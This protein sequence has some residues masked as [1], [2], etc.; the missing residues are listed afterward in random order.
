MA[1][2]D[3]TKLRELLFVVVR[4]LQRFKKLRQEDDYRFSLD[5]DEASSS[6]PAARFGEIILEGGG[7]GVHLLV[8][9]DTYNNLARWVNRK[10]LSEFE[11]RVLFQMSANDSANLIDSQAASNLGLH[12]AL[13]YNEHEGTLET[14]RPYALPESDWIEEI[15]GQIAR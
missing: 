9:V 1:V 11:M 3:L 2:V 13:L 8:S 14:F 10:A 6:N 12:R 15:G 7:N 4:D 5:S